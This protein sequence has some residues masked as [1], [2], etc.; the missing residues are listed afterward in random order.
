MFRQELPLPEDKGAEVDR[1]EVA[2]LALP[3]LHG[4]VELAECVLSPGPTEVLLVD[5]EQ[6][7][8]AQV[9]DVEHVGPQAKVGRCLHP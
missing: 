4:G 6:G 5:G 2:V 3:V 9:G 7:R 1:A 8:V